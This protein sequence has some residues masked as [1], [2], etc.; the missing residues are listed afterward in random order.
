MPPKK[1]RSLAVPPFLNEGIRFPQ[2]GQFIKD[3]DFQ[4]IVDALHRR[5]IFALA[6]L[7]QSPAELPPAIKKWFKGLWSIELGHAQAFFSAYPDRM[8]GID[9][10]V[11]E[12]FGALTRNSQP[13]KPSFL[14]TLK[15]EGIELPSLVELETLS[16]DLGTD[17]WWTELPDRLSAVQDA[18]P[19]KK[20]RKARVEDAQAQPPQKKPHTAKSGP[21]ATTDASISSVKARKGKVKMI[22]AAPMATSGAPPTN[23][24]G[25]AAGTIKAPKEKKKAT[26]A[27]SKVIPETPPAN[28]EGAPSASLAAQQRNDSATKAKSQASFKVLP[29]NAEDK[30]AARSKVLK[31]SES[32][33]K[34]ATKSA[35]DADKPKAKS[36]PKP[37]IASM[38]PDAQEASKGLS[39]G[40]VNNPAHS[41]L[42]I[43]KERSQRLN[44]ISP[45]E[46]GSVSQCKSGRRVPE[47]TKKVGNKDSLETTPPSEGQS[48]VSKLIVPPAQADRSLDDGS[49]AT[50]LKLEGVKHL[51]HLVINALKS[52]EE[53]GTRLDANVT[54]LRHTFDGVVYLQKPHAS[55]STARTKKEA[56][57]EKSS[58]ESAPPSALKPAQNQTVLHMNAAPGNRKYALSAIPHRI[59]TG[60][61]SAASSTSAAAVG[62]MLADTSGEEDGSEKADVDEMET[63]DGDPEA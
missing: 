21:A 59:S 19:K 43:E 17:T 33:S 51:L 31:Q 55:A 8:N 38:R 13:L 26:K 63:D 28:V 22:K 54:K 40:N 49:A 30:P 24:K 39:K 57:V 9:V 46:M 52:I 16:L 15:G 35:T 62:D 60:A 37:A 23:P 29:A 4:A 50:A 1:L 2:Q 41:A 36:T 20:K 34:A 25:A 45:A 6:H 7:G 48:R 58:T 61:A 14:E 3:A 27:E 12:L 44:R 10:G 18:E 5:I 56:Q 42:S 47:E 11:P 53:Q 32:A